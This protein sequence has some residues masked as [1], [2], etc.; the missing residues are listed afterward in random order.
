MKRNKLHIVTKKKNTLFSKIVLSSPK[1]RLPFP[2]Q[3]EYKIA[4]GKVYVRNRKIE[5]E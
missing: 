5:R 3:K 4:S 1:Q 2:Y